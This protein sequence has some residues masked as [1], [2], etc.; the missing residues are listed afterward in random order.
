[1]TGSYPVD[2][3][4]NPA[5]AMKGAVMRERRQQDLRSADQKQAER[6]RAK[7]V[8]YSRETE[9]LLRQFLTIEVGQGKN[10]NYRRGHEFTF[11]WSESDKKLALAAMDL[12]MSFDEAFDYVKQLPEDQKPKPDGTGP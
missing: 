1:M 5:L 2:A 11:E 3:G 4:S 8:R 7:E 9:Q 10:A 12:G 6:D